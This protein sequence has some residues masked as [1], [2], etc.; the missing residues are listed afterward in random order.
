MADYTNVVI[1]GSTYTASGTSDTYTS[2][3]VT[4]GGQGEAVKDVMCGI[5]PQ[6]GMAGVA[7]R[8]SGGVAAIRELEELKS[9]S[10]ANFDTAAMTLSTTDMILPISDEVQC[11][12][13]STGEWLGADGLSRTMGFSDKFTVYY[14]RAPELGGKVRIIVA[15]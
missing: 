9:L 6:S 10:R 3:T 13:N 4:N 7:L 8:S 1:N 2:T 12:I 14:D 5:G 11:Y 15:H